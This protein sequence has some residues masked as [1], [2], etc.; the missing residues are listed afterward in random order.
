VTDRFGN[1][2][3]QDA[4]TVNGEATQDRYVYT[5]TDATAP[6]VLDAWMADPTPP[7]G[8]PTTPGL[9]RTL[10]VTFSEEMDL[11]TFTAANVQIVGPNG[12]A[13]L[14]G[15]GLASMTNGYTYTISFQAAG[16]G[17]HTLTIGAAV[18]DL[19]GNRLN[20]DADTT[21]GEATQDRFQLTFRV[22]L[23][24]STGRPTLD[25]DDAYRLRER[26]LEPIRVIDPI[27][28]TFDPT[29][30]PFRPGGWEP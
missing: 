27:D 7:P 25:P 9:A 16:Y 26:G 30:D 19:F 14:G 11:S 18:T 6:R 10:V 28:P 8:F 24:A 29:S 2:M 22:D 4:D 13:T 17:S 21:F 1:P 5:Y 12:T 20:Q 3:N 15:I 23:L